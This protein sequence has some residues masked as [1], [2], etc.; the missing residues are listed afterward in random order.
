MKVLFMPC[1]IGMGHV[2][3][4][5]AISKE[6]EKNNVEIGF[7][8]YGSGY[9]ILREYYGYTVSKLPDI[10]FYGLD[11][12]LNLK[13]TLKKS[14]DMPYIFLKSIYHESRII[15]E[16]QP[17]LIVADS[18]YSV[19]ITARILGVP[20][21]LMTNELKTNF[22][23]IYPEEK[24]VT[25]IENGLDKFVRD[26]CNQCRVIMVPDIEG[27]IKVPKKIEN[28]VVHV[29]PFLNRD[30]S[31]LKNKQ[32]LKDDFGFERSDKIVL[33]TV[34]GSEFGGELLKLICKASSNINCDKI[35]MVTGP[36]IDADFIQESNKIVKK[37]FL[38]KMMEWMKISDVIVSLAGHNTLT[39]ILSL[40]IPNVVVPIDNH[41]EQ[42][43]N[44]LNVEGHGISIVE[45]IKKL[46]SK[47]L[48][49][50]INHLLEDSIIAKRSTIVKNKFL[51]YN[52][53]ENTV[54]IIMDNLNSK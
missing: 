7:A 29:G 10:K 39:E 21:L 44:S 27:S 23:Q 42:L 38:D 4:S 53:L 40:G 52:G 20:C 54:T 9:D 37:K 15:K 32:H 35:V 25:Y 47:K 46:N 6:L 28:K 11:G 5:V 1:G 16:F 50:D 2:S 48:T 45:D 8:S 12:E 19:P 3:R 14:I 43:R 18:Q 33:V 49:N 17:D 51:S 36:K 22:S 30:P 31:T 13:Y 24:T 26:V 34:G 41:P